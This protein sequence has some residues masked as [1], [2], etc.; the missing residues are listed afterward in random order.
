MCW[1]RLPG[2]VMIPRVDLT[3][4]FAALDLDPD[5]PDDAD[6]VAVLHALVARRGLLR[7][8]RRGAEPG[9]AVSGPRIERATE[10]CV[11]GPEVPW[12]R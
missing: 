12:V 5:D 1:R 7:A 4:A 9:P 8:R 11:G 2:W 6:D 3:A 10:R